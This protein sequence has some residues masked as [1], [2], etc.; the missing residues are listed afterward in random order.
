MRQAFT[1]LRVA[2]VINA[3]EAHTLQAQNLFQPEQGV[4]VALRELKQRF[5]VVK[6]KNPLTAPK[7]ELVE[8]LSGSLRRAGVEH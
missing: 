2:R 7:C 6:V 4:R 5:H 1:I 8:E 3:N